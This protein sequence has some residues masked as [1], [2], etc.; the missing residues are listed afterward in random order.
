MILLISSML[1][2]IGFFSHFQLSGRAPNTY[3]TLIAPSSPR[4]SSVFTMCFSDEI[5][6]YE[7][8]NGV[9]SSDDYAEELLQMAISVSPS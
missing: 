7:V 3:T 5:I 8:F 1:S 6:D 2:C 9:M 4:C